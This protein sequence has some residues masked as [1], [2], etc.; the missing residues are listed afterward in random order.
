MRELN[1]ATVMAL[2]IGNNNFFIEILGGARG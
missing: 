1:L 2:N